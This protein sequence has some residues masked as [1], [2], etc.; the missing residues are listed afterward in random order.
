M[1]AFEDSSALPIDKFRLMIV[2]YLI[3]SGSDKP[4][5]KEVESALEKSIPRDSSDGYWAAYEYV[6]KYFMC[7]IIQ[8]NWLDSNDTSIF[9]NYKT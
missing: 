3:M 5:I 1:G 2:Y 9:T 7:F 8:V 4:K 6:K